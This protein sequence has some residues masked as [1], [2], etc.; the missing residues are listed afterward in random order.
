MGVKQRI[1]LLAFFSI[2]FRVSSPVPISD[3]GF[4]LS[5]SG[6]KCLPGAAAT[7][8]G[9]PKWGRRRR[10]SGEEF[11]TIHLLLNSLH[12]PHLF[13]LLSY[14]F[15]VEWNILNGF[16][17]YGFGR[18]LVSG[19]GDVYVTQCNPSGQRFPAW[20][21]EHQHVNSFHLDWGI[22]EWR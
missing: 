19:T 12:L 11:G 9:D 6:T 2:Y 20:A 8:L 15:T 4:G 5:L 3:H 13:F 22:N 21:G 1:A 16:W 14:I 10:Y 7:L 17:I 18:P